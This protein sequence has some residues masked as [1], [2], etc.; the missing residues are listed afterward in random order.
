MQT[1][2]QIISQYRDQCAARDAAIRAA[3]QEITRLRRSVVKPD[4]TEHVEAAQGAVKAA[5]QAFE[6]TLKQ[7][8][9]DN[10]QIQLGAFLA[11]GSLSE[12]CKQGWAEDKN[13]ASLWL[14]ARS[15]IL[16]VP[17][18]RESYAQGD[19]FSGQNMRHTLTAC[20]VLGIA[21]AEIKAVV[22]AIATYNELRGF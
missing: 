21:E 2:Q 4:I 6:I 16:N 15:G 13:N 5:K 10:V 11:Q 12:I 19:L 14:L 3:D 9:T 18:W 22:T 17:M 7:A 1:A 20:K 8:C